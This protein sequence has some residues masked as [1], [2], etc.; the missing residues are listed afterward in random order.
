MDGCMPNG[1]W[2]RNACHPNGRKKWC[3][4]FGSAPRQRPAPAGRRAPARACRRRAA[5]QGRMAQRGRRT[6]G[7]SSVRHL[8]VVGPAHRIN[9]LPGAAAI[10]C[11][12][13]W[14]NR[15]AAGGRRCSRISYP[16]PAARPARPGLERRAAMPGRWRWRG[17]RDASTSRCRRCC[18]SA[19]AFLLPD[20]RDPQC[21]PAY[22][23]LRSGRTV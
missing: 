9:W 17:R 1:V 15:P 2:Q 20:L 5:A 18:C 14:P 6:A 16:R 19:P 21:F 13:A 4:V 7:C 3:A 23:S 12:T 11:L 22:R 10:V 8:A